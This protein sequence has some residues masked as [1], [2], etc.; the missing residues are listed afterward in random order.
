[1]NHLNKIRSISLATVLLVSANVFATEAKSSTLLYISP[2]DYKYSVHLL[3]PYYNYWFEQGPL[4]EP[5][6]L[7]ALKAE[8]SDANLCQANETADKIIRVTPSL[9][10]NPQLQMYYSKLTA[11]VYSGSGNV[12]ATYVGEGKQ[13]GFTAVNHAITMHLSK[14]YSA[15]MQDLMTKID[16]GK[17]T[18]DK[19][20][21]NLAAQTK[22]PC[23]L[24][25]AQAEP[26]VGYY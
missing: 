8:N 12:L 11:T 26:K 23:G 9:F 25:G 7:S 1:M 20:A 19:T 17:L 13:H 5:I 21:A 6:A 15:A 14:A 3:H 16:A 18:E 22:L 4:V 2:N 24:I 10:Y